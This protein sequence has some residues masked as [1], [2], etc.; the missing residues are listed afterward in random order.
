MNNASGAHARVTV[1]AVC[2][3]RKDI[4]VLG[5]ETGNPP[6]FQTFASV[7][8]PLGT[9]SVG[10]GVFSAP[11]STAINLHATWPDSS[12]SWRVAE[13]NASDITD[14]FIEPGVVCLK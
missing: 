11:S 13:N 9:T 4:H 8:C 5:A 1:Y 10:G 7:A 14:A 3:R 6:G 12:S 2:G